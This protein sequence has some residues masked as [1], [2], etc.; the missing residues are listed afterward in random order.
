MER[1]ARATAGGALAIV[2]SSRRR[3]SRT[4][5]KV[6]RG[7][8]AAEVK[9]EGAEAFVQASDD[10]Q[11]QHR[12]GDRLAKV[13]EIFGY[14]LEAPTVVDDGQVALGEGA[15]LLVGVEGARDA[16]P[17]ELGVDGEPDGA[18]TSPALTDD[19]G[20]VVGDCAE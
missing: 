1:A 19:V 17:K 9:A 13:L 8:A 12:L 2:I 6:G 4:C 18:S 10:V 20:E 5:R 16:I 3:S 7:V 11:D 15:E 14:A